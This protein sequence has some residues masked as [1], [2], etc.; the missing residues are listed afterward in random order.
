[1]T[2]GD[3]EPDMLGDG[4]EVLE[5]DDGDD[6]FCKAGDPTC[7]QPAVQNQRQF[8]GSGAAAASDADSAVIDLDAEDDRPSSIRT[9]RSDPCNITPFDNVNPQG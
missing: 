5:V 4:V 1:M 2:A 9:S 3:A 8:Q 7:R 6:G